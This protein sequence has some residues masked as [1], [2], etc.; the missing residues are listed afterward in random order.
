MPELSLD[1]LL[2]QLSSEAGKR[3][4]PPCVV[5]LGEDAYLRDLAH[6]HLLD[7]C[8]PAEMR[9]WAVTRISLAE[10]GLYDVLQQA[11]SLPMLCPKQVI[12]ASDLEALAGNE[13][14]E[15]KSDKALEALAE[16][17][18]DPAPFTT[19]VLE[20]PGLDQRTKLSKLLRD[21]AVVVSVSFDIE[22][23]GDK[24]GLAAPLVARMA[25]DAGVEMDLDTAA[26][27][28]DCLDGDLGRIRCE[29]EKLAAYAGD[30]KRIVAADL[31]AVVVSA[32]KYTVW[33]LA[34][35]LS[36]GERSRA[37]TFLDSVL[38]E[39]EEPAGVVGAMAWMYRKLIEAQELPAHTNKFQAAGK[40]KM[41]PDAAETALQQSR[42]IPRQRLLDGIV[43]LAEADDRLKS[44]HKNPRAVME[45]LIAN[46][47]AAAAES[48]PRAGRRRASSS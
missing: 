13:E 4:T 20:S 46:L 21:K 6:Q 3:K 5:L 1:R 44:G 15:K 34:E 8:V 29:V 18:Q 22:K 14:D 36:S 41:R 12:F 28:A 37:M 9:D 31:A 38:R 26:Q 11:Q 40:L 48:S 35:I 39:G 33:Q 19:L 17:L 43:A 45:F 27:L 32:K 30:A 23:A 25:R 10:S 7:A 42:A 24:I 47:T 16:Y 2:A